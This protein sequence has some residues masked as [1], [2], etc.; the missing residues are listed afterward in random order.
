MA[1]IQKRRLDRS[2]TDNEE[3]AFRAWTRMNF[4]AR[5]FVDPLWHPVVRSECYAIDK[6]AGFVRCS[7]ACYSGVEGDVPVEALVT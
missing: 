2:L 5:A 4:V 3:N 1:Y 7:V 6:E